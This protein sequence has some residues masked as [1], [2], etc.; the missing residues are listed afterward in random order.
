MI[1]NMIYH[2]IC[3]LIVTNYSIIITILHFNP[4]P[5]TCEYR[6]NNIPNKSHFFSYCRREVVAEE[7]GSNSNSYEIKANDHWGQRRPQAQLCIVLQCANHF[8]YLACSKAYSPARSLNNV[9]ICPHFGLHLFIIRPY[10]FNRTT[11]EYTKRVVNTDYELSNA[12]L[13]F[14]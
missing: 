3:I 10:I 8:T 2:T 9:I 12:V 7:G 14:G 5:K 13:L 11:I 6:N 1:D 4:N